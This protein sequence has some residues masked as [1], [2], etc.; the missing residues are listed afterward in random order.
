MTDKRSSTE[1]LLEIE[2]K[3]D[4]LS[5]RVQNMENLYKIQLK[6]MNAQPKSAPTVEPS[7]SQQQVQQPNQQ[8]SPTLQQ[9]QQPPVQ[10]SD[11]TVNKEV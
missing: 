5:L 3:L 7:A 9:P 6:R 1:I 8:P 10:V 2:R 4:T 11:G